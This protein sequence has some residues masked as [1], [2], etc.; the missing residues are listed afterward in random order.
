MNKHKQTLFVTC[1]PKGV[2]KSNCKHVAS[3]YVINPLPPTFVTKLN[4][5]TSPDSANTER[6][7]VAL[8]HRA[9][10]LYTSLPLSS[11]PMITLA[12]SRSTGGESRSSSPAPT[13]RLDDLPAPTSIARCAAALHV[14]RVW[15]GL[16]GRAPHA[17]LLVAHLRKQ[18]DE[19]LL[20]QSVAAEEA[21]AP[22]RVGGRVCGR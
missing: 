13:G 11:H 8:G 19:K 21:R 20:A 2:S 22:P 16:A 6:G 7:R 14:Q 5:Q 15:R 12:R 3:F 18:R 9:G 17:K 10:Q 4:L 1:L